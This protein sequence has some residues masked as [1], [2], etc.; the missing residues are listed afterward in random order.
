LV[1]FFLLP[2]CFSFTNVS[3][4]NQCLGFTLGRAGQRKPPH[5]R[6]P[7]FDKAPGKGALTKGCEKREA[8][9]A[10]T[11]SFC[12]GAETSSASMLWDRFIGE[13]VEWEDLPDWAPTYDVDVYACTHTRSP[14]VFKKKP[15]SMS[16]PSSP[17][18]ALP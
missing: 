16:L 2:R 7:A 18:V 1:S 3:G 6:S 14:V 4:Q 15:L 11:K 13:S 10:K 8:W 17:S 12:G 9:S 5:P